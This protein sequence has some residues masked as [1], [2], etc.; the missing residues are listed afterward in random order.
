MMFVL[1]NSQ[2]NPMIIEID[3]KG[4]TKFLNAKPPEGQIKAWSVEKA[5]QLAYIRKDWKS[6]FKILNAT[7]HKSDDLADTMVQI[8]ALCCHFEWG[9]TPIPKDWELMPAM[10]GWQSGQIFFR[11]LHALMG[12]DASD[13]KI[14]RSVKIWISFFSKHK[15]DEIILSR[16]KLNVVVTES[17]RSLNLVVKSNISPIFLTNGHSAET[18]KLVL[19]Q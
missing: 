8:E 2:L 1:K 14:N 17:N 4:K 16:D 15:D 5:L 9:S 11:H 13:L 3:S 10:S 19:N 18:I 6:F 12:L 7:R